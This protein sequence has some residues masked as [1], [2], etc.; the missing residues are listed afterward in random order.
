[1]LP[2][3]R[4]SGCGSPRIPDEL[5]A[6]ELGSRGGRMEKDGGTE[7]EIKLDRIGIWLSMNASEHGVRG[8]AISCF[9]SHSRRGRGFRRRFPLLVP[10]KT[11]E[12]GEKGEQRAGAEAYA[13][14]RALARA[15]SAEREQGTGTGEE[16]G[17]GGEYSADSPITR[18]NTDNSTVWSRTSAD[19]LSH[20]EALGKDD[21]VHRTRQK[22]FL[23]FR[24]PVPRRTRTFTTHLP[25]NRK[26]DKLV[27]LLARFLSEIIPPGGDEISPEWKIRATGSTPD[28]FVSPLSLSLFSSSFTVFFLFLLVFLS[29]SLGF[30]P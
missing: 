20:E 2:Q 17:K 24:Q 29:P 14:G 4:Q 18:Q 11:A 6:N 10:R 8:I 26:N 23:P 13:S 9:R 30:F 7:V 28:F 19:I 5:D 21:H 3:A 15:N 16:G 22:G 27:D 1:M 12:D 25:S